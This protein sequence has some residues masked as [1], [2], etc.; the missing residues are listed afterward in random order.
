MWETDPAFKP[1]LQ[2]V[3][4]DPLRAKCRVCNVVMVAELTVI[5][6]HAKGKKHCSYLKTQST[7]QSQIARAEIKLAGFLS[8]HNIPFN[9]TEHLTDLLKDIF[10][11]SKIAQSMS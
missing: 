6:N 3:F 9:V 2:E 5:K 8:E 4:N 7:L 10:P 1:W 11:D